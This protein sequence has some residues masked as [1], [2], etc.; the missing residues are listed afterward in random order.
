VTIL[1]FG[2]EGLFKAQRKEESHLPV[3]DFRVVRKN[4]EEEKSH[5]ALRLPTGSKSPRLYFSSTFC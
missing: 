2:T 1:G 4:H 5:Q 3:F